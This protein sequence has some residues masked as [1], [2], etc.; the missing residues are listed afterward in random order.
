MTIA[1]QPEQRQF[2]PESLGARLVLRPWRP[3]GGPRWVRE[4]LERRTLVKILAENTHN[5]ENWRVNSNV[6]EF[7]TFFQL[8]RAGLELDC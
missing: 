1:Q 5:S 2:V 3:P 8:P 7:A 6:R 4:A